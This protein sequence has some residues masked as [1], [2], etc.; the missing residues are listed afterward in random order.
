MSRG[1]LMA[2][3]DVSLVVDRIV[4]TTTINGDGTKDAKATIGHRFPVAVRTFTGTR[5]GLD[6]SNVQ[7]V[8]Q[9]P[10]G[11]R[12]PRKVAA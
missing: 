5:A 8:V 2:S 3:T 11:G 6:Y 4:I 9:L 10:P 7:R 1:F 12:W